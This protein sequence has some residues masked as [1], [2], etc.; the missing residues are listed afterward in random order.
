MYFESPMIEASSS[1]RTQIGNEKI[2]SM[3]QNNSSRKKTRNDKDS[4]SHNSDS[5]SDSSSSGDDEDDV[6]FE[7]HEKKG[8]SNSYDNNCRNRGSSSRSGDRGKTQVWSGDP[9]EEAG[10]VATHVSSYFSRLW[11]N[12]NKSRVWYLFLRKLPLT[13]KGP[14]AGGPEIAVDRK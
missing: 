2:N 1:E 10:H 13:L 6:A 9:G 8:H 11:K 12:G 14:A 5:S 7:R 3:Q 4:Y